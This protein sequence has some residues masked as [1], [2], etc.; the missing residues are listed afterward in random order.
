MFSEARDSDPTARLR[1]AWD[2]PRVWLGDEQ[3]ARVAYLL[4][5]EV[6]G[7]LESAMSDLTA[8][9]LVVKGMGLAATVYP[10]PWLREMG[11]I[12]LLVRPQDSAQLLERLEQVGMQRVT[13]PHARRLSSASFG[14]TALLAKVGP[15]QVTVEVHDQ[16]DKLARRRVD[17]R[18]I[19][20]RSA[21]Y[22]SSSQLRVPS[23]DDHFM[24]VVLHLAASEFAHPVGWLDLEL[25]LRA[26]ADLD[27]VVGRAREWRLQT[28]TWIAL[29]ALRSL[30]SPSVPERITDALC[31][32]PARRRILEFWYRADDYPVGRYPLQLGWPWVIRQTPLYDDTLAWLKSVA[33]YG[34]RRALEQW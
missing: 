33:A 34:A 3:H 15:A 27:T 20:E 17:Y 26:G 21:P 29:K 8:R 32:G 25:L 13:Q 31:P 23:L 6:M 14:E 7:Q 9:V 4:R 10:Q 30:G 22:R 24:L 1:R 2:D 19:F 11:D 5:D 12:D 16:L 18:A 28:A